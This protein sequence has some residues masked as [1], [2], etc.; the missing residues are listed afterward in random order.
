[1]GTIAELAKSIFESNS[2][3]HRRRLEAIRKRE[4]AN[5][6]EFERLQKRAK[7]AMNKV[8]SRPVGGMAS[9]SNLEPYS[10]VRGH[11]GYK[12]YLEH[13]FSGDVEVVVVNN[14]GVVGAR[15]ISKTV[16]K[17]YKGP[18][19]DII[20][21]EAVRIIHEH[22]AMNDFRSVSIAARDILEELD[23]DR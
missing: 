5:T 1:M 2:A 13:H 19:M 6:M 16:L 17:R 14:E 15:K 11:P 7:A 20:H 3:E 22:E 8:A 21:D 18:S 9:D 12:Y 10:P 4:I 23:G